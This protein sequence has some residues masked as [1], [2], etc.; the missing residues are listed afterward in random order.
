MSLGTVI[1]LWCVSSMVLAPFVGRAIR[2]SREEPLVRER[3]SAL[4]TA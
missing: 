4:E 1:L 2:N 3:A